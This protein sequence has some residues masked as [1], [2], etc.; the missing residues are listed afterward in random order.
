[1]PHRIAIAALLCAAAAGC[2]NEKTAVIAQV[3]QDWDC[4]EEATQVSEVSYGTYRLDGCGRSKTYQCN[5]ALTVPRCWP[6]QN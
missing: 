4:A 6:Y 5:F 2:V 1:M 3:R